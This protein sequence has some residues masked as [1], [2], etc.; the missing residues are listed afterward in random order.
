M[1]TARKDP[2]LTP[3]PYFPASPPQLQGPAGSSNTRTSSCLEPTLR[4]L[5]VSAST[6]KPS[7]GAAGGRLD[8]RAHSFLATSPL[9][10]IESS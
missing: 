6:P 8:Q 2:A 9:A 3:L 4:S 1:A 5:A 7:H 10:H